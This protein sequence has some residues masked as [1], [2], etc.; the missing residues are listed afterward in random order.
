VYIEEM[1]DMVQYCFSEFRRHKIVEDIKKNTNL[2]RE[3]WI[4]VWFLILQSA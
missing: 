4:C 1:L 2:L 3:R